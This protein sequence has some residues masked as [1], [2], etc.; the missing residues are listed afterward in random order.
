MHYIVNDGTAKGN[1]H[2]YEAVQSTRGRFVKMRIEYDHALHRVRAVVQGDISLISFVQTSWHDPLKPSA[3]SVIDVG[4][5]GEVAGSDVIAVT[6]NLDD[7]IFSLVRRQRT[8]DQF[9]NR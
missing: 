7:L 8:M 1:R 5:R 6:P 9:L 2:W 4:H 3:A